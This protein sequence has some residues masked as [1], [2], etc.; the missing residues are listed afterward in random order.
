MTKLLFAT[1][2]P[3][4][5]AELRGLLGSALVSPDAV[6]SLVDFPGTPEVV[7]D[8]E[9]FVENACKKALGYAKARGVPA[10]ADD[11]GLCVDALGGAPGVH[12]AR[13]APGDDRARVE[14]LLGAMAGVADEKRT[15]RFQCALCLAFPTGETMTTLGSCE[16]RIAHAPR[17]EHGFG[18]DPVFVVEGKGVT[19]SELTREQKSEVSHRGK[20]FAAMLP[21]LL[22]ALGAN[23]QASARLRVR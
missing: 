12:S 3:G 21:R 11:S 8:G 2:N 14:K 22:A 15:A 9:T 1:T 10:L 23:G 13:Y 5:L 17:G 7:E 19:L 20:A 18:Y 4:K 6:L 16:G